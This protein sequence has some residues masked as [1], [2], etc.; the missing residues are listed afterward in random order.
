M[1]DNRLAAA[2]RQQG[3]DVVLVPLYTPL[4]TDEADVSLAHVFYGGLNV[5]LQQ[6]TWLFRHTPRFWD[7]LFDAPLLLRGLGRF[8][9]R[10]RPAA[11]GALTVSVLRGPDGAQR[12]ELARLIEA[13]RTLSPAVV[14]LP[15]LLFVGVAGALQAALHVPIVCT[16][17]GEDLFVDGL[18][19]PWRGQVLD[20]IR[21]R[22]ADV[23]GFVAPTDYYAQ[24]AA[25]CFGLPAAR[26]ERVPMGIRTA[27]FT[28]APAYGAGP[29]TIGYLARICPEKGVDELG[30]AFTLVHKTGR[31][32]RLRIAGY[33]GAADKPYFRRVRA[34][35]AAGG[36]D[37]EHVGEV[38]R[39]GKLEFLRGLHVLSVP[40]RYRESKGFYV[41]E[42][43]AS[44]VPVVLPEHGS[45]P[46]LVAATGGGLL[47]APGDTAALAGTLGRLIDDV[48]LHRELSARG[49]AAVHAQFT[50]ERMAT[51][52]WSV[53]ERIV[54][55]SRAL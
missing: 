30:R 39:D 45:F 1:H 32:C 44:G 13:V 27:D 38:T 43:L 4:R 37:F 51:A 50:V 17:A 7:R 23:D 54:Q 29:F 41:L 16:L 21:T 12:K 48:D 25:A 47:H 24:H 10:T 22:A 34:E 35:L 14:H 33:L 28:A 8:A 18:P 19:P 49:R 46:E 52:V 31:A 55:R 20:L 53:Y 36:S 3:R 2:L 26:I 15:N 6:A 5:Y 9:A 42:A 11:L 40:T